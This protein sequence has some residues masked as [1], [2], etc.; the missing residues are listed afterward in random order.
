MLERRLPLDELLEQLRALL[1]GEPD[2]VANAANCVAL[3]WQDFHDINWL[4]FY[5]RQGNELVLGPF[6]GKPA[7]VRIPIGQGVCGMAVAEAR[8]QVVPDVHAFDGHI[9]CDAQSRSE[10]VVPLF[11]GETVWGVLDVD[12]PLVDRFT[13]E[14]VVRLEAASAA[15]ARLCSPATGA[16]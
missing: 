8:T 1:C 9:A 5:F 14:D 4:G 12:S 3:L 16:R 10:V 15:F 11:S 7:C 6:Q 13:A 2:P